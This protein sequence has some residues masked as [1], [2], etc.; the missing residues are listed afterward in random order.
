MTYKE[1]YEELWDGEYREKRENDT[2]IFNFVYYRIFGGIIEYAKMNEG[3]MPVGVGG[4]ITFAD[5]GCGDGGF[6]N[7]L[8][9]N[10][11]VNEVSALIDVADNAV[12]DVAR[13]RNFVCRDISKY[14][15]SVPVTISGCL[16]V[17]EH[18]DWGD[19]T[20]AL[21]NIF[22]STSKLVF[23]TVSNTEE[24]GL[25]RTLLSRKEWAFFILK[26]AM[27]HGFKQFFN[28]MWGKNHF[29]FAYRREVE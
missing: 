14:R 23:I 8:W 12:I 21:H 11:L 16:D 6:A 17:L 3:A 2:R 7:Y 19:A 13:R 20:D 4:H 28:F 5:W 1:T 26:P 22:C 25:H 15:L 29:G 9:A 27:F 18:L 24:D 10:G